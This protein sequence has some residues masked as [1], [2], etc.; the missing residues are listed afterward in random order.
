VTGGPPF[1][2]D[3]VVVRRDGRKDDRKLLEPPVLVVEVSPG[4]LVT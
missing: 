4:V 3:L 1:A 2:P